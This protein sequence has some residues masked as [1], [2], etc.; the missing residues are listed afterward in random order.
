MRAVAFAFLL[1]MMALIVWLWGFGGAHV[2]R[3]W[4]AATQHDVQNAM[5]ASMRALKAGQPGALATLWTLCFTYGFVHAAGPGHGK[6]IIGG[7]GVGARVTAARLAGLAAVSSLAQALSA[8]VF[9]YLALWVLGWGRAQMAHLADRIMAPL[10]YGM[11]ACVG[12]WLLWRGLRKTWAQR[13][14]NT[15]HDHH[16]HHHHDHHHGDGAVCADCGHAHGPTAAQAAAVRSWRDAVAVIAAIAI[17]PCTG[18]VFLLILTHALGLS[19]AGIA[20]A[21]VMGLGTALFTALVALSAVSL[22]E[23]TLANVA[24]SQTVARLLALAEMLAGLVIAVL[25]IQLLLRII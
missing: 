15:A 14:Q 21:F 23:S 18:A 19:W 8:V 7:Y 17:R 3:V 6:L 13:S 16:D 4:A 25:A 5:A 9:V 22:R 12:G 11:I 2:V 10:S 24:S 20:G 1:A